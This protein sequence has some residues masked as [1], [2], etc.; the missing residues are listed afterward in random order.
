MDQ[1]PAGNPV[2]V[3]DVGEEEGDVLVGVVEGNAI[4]VRNLR[5]LNP[6]LIVPCVISVPNVIPN[7]PC[8]DQGTNGLRQ[9]DPH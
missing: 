4:R 5:H 9:E 2:Q 8:Q 3:A 7:G 1:V 6:Q